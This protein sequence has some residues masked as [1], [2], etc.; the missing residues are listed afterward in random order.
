MIRLHEKTKQ[1][2]IEAVEKGYP[3]EK[4]IDKLVAAGH[5]RNVV[6]KLAKAALNERI[7]EIEPNHDYVADQKTAVKV[8]AEILFGVFIR[9][10]IGFIMFITLSTVI[11]DMAGHGGFI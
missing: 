10:A 11:L 9:L 8:T 5:K 7:Q 3:V 1:Y 6:E 4:V 2:I